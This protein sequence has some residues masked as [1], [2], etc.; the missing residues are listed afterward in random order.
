MAFFFILMSL[1]FRRAVVPQPQPQP[2]MAYSQRRAEPIRVGLALGLP[3]KA[4][5]EGRHVL[6]E[7]WRGCLFLQTPLS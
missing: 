3:H 1:P 2:Q 5:G 4:K 6:K 7:R